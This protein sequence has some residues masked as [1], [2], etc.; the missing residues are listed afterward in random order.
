MH[1]LRTFNWIT[2]LFRRRGY[3][4]GKHDWEYRGFA[5][6]SGKLYHCRKC[7]MLTG[8]KAG[9]MGFDDHRAPRLK[10]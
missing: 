10:A 1:V 5:P 4:K 7:H 2:W 6:E 9:F 3:R 8:S